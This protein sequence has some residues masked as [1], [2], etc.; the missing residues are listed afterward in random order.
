MAYT[1]CNYGVSYSD[2]NA[3]LSAA[4]PFR[5]TFRNYSTAYG[6]STCVRGYS[7]AKVKGSYSSGIVV[8][9]YDNTG[10]EIPNSSVSLTSTNWTEITIPS[11]AYIM[12]PTYSS[13]SSTVRYLYY[14]LFA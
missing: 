7:K 5:L 3:N 13:S 2:I 11:G 14:A 9:F 6:A 1:E 8:K 10:T 4:D 12:A